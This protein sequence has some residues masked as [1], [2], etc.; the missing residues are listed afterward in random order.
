MLIPDFFQCMDAAYVNYLLVDAFKLPLDFKVN[1]L[2]EVKGE[3]TS[4]ALG[5]AYHFF[6]KG[7]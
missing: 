1:V 5:A 3:E 2:K 4:W 7:S 6:N